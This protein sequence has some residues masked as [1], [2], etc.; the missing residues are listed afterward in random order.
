MAQALAAKLGMR[1]EE[2]ESQMNA[3]RQIVEEQSKQLKELLQEMHESQQRHRQEMAKKDEMIQ[4]MLKKMQED[5]AKAEVAR[6]ERE[7][8]LEQMCKEQDE[9]RRAEQQAS[10]DLQQKL[11]DQMQ[12]ESAKAQEAKGGGRQ[13]A[14]RHAAENAKGPPGGYEGCSRVGWWW[15]FSSIH[16]PGDSVWPEAHLGV[17]GWGQSLGSGQQRA[18]LL[19]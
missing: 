8:Q 12:A 17:A 4:E 11:L 5:Q 9:Q 14:P 6:Q 10:A 2:L 16:Y 3:M 15:L 18:P 13:E 19:R 7:R 1:P